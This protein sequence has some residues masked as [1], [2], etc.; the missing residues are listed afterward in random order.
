MHSKPADFD[1]TLTSPLHSTIFNAA[2][3]AVVSLNIAE[4]QKCNADKQST[5]L[6]C[7]AHCRNL[8]ES[9]VDPEKTLKKLAVLSDSG[10]YFLGDYRKPTIDCRLNYNQGVC[11]K[12]FGWLNLIRFTKPQMETSKMVFL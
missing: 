9:V 1:V 7:T 2:D 11:L 4:E 10:S 3:K 5:R 6:F 12:N 8:W